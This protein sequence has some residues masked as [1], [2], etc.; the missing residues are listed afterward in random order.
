M[1]NANAP[2]AALR[3]PAAFRK[4]R[5]TAT[6]AGRVAPRAPLPTFYTRALARLAR[7]GLRPGLY[8]TAREFSARVGAEIP[9]L[10]TPLSR[11]TTAYETARFGGQ[12]PTPQESRDLLELAARL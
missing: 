12:N 1:T 10:V 8:E 6:P 3:S 2:A 5:R 4:V 9:V 7:R 11:I